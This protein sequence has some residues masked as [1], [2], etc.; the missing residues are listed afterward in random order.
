METFPQST[1][2]DADAQS[3]MKMGELRSVSVKKVLYPGRKFC[4]F[5]GSFIIGYERLYQDYKMETQ[6][7]HFLDP[8][9]RLRFTTLAL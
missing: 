9:L 7:F 1:Y 8:I 2:I 6:E 5:A 4:T 3:S